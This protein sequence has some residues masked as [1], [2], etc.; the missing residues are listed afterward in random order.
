MRSEKL[1]MKPIRKK[2]GTKAGLEK[3]GRGC[4]KGT[5]MYEQVSRSSQVRK[6][7]SLVHKAQW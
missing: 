5:V 3:F 7:H 4:L 1:R 6:A 2:P